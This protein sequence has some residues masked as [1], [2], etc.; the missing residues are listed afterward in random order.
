MKIILLCLFIL[1]ICLFLI[2]SKEMVEKFTNKMYINELYNEPMKEIKCCLVE[3]KY[4]PDEKNILG[5]NFK[6][7]YTKMENEMCQ[8]KKYILDNNKQLLIDG[9]N[10]WSNDYCD[11]NKT[12]LGSC[13]NVNK[14]CIDFVSKIFCDKYNLTWSPKTC[15]DPLDYKWIDKTKFTKP[16]PISDNTYLM[17]NKESSLK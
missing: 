12:N 8:S 13:R 9:N 3:K 16:I 15:H 6:Y 14:E 4:L 2:F 5:G 11:E 7:K 17:F 1:L 10:N